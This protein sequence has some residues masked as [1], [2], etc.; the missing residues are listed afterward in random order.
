[1]ASRI[2]SQHEI[3]FGRAV[4]LATD[5]LDMRA[6]GAFWLYDKK[7]D[8]WRYFLV[9]SL[10]ERIDPR[11]VYVCLNNA[12]SKILSS[13]EA[14]DLRLFIASP[15]DSLVKELLLQ[16]STSPRASVPKQATVKIGGK[17]T[18]SFIYRLSKGLAMDQAKKAQRQFRRSCR[19]LAIT[20]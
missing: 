9:T 7:D 17:S 4:L 16:T 12:F 2:L 6:E 3:D 11:D 18:D 19:E 1:M 5:T 8:E 13:E 14:D 15:T 10:F 20:A